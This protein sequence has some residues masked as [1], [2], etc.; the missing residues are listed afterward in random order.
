MLHAAFMRGQGQA[1]KGSGWRGQAQAM[2]GSG[3]RGQGQALNSSVL[4]IFIWQKSLLPYSAPF[5]WMLC[6]ESQVRVRVRLRCFVVIWGHKGELCRA[7]VG[8]RRI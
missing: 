7:R 1:M 2:K 3:W 4:H 6:G 5:F 8:V